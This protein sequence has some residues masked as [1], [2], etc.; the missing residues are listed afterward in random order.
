MRVATE[1]TQNMFRAS[2]GALRIN[3]PF[4]AVSLANERGKDFWSSKR[5][6]SAVET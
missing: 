2:E 1:V 4:L 6:Q 5:L 3:N